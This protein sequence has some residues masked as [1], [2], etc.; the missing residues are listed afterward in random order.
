MY[1]DQMI[2][3]AQSLDIKIF[4]SEH[5]LKNTILRDYI[6]ILQVSWAKV[7]LSYL[8]PDLPVE[9]FFSRMFVVNKKDRG[10]WPILDIR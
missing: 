1:G 10:V 3:M 7:P 9:G 2:Q 6:Q 5:K 4:T 8:S